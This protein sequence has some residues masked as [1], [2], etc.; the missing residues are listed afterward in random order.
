MKK[1]ILLIA[2]GFLLSLAIPQELQHVTGVVNV[3]V[4]VRVFD[5][6]KFV[7]DL[8]I[9]D[10]AVFEDGQP[11][12]IAALYMIR[13]TK[14]QKEEAAG[15]AATTP[16]P[17]TGRHIVLL[18]EVNDPLPK[19]NEALDFFFSEVLQPE[20]TLTVTTPRKTYHLK[21]ET[22]AHVPR[23]EVARQLKEKLRPD[24]V[25]GASEYRSILRDIRDLVNDFNVDEDLKEQMLLEYI[26][27]LR[28]RIGL[29]ESRLRAFAQTLKVQ[30]GQKYVFLFYQRERVVLPPLSDFASTELRR[31]LDFNTKDIERIFADA[32]LTVHLIYLTQTTTSALEI[33]DQMRGSTLDTKDLSEN[34]Y[35]AFKEMAQ[36]TGGITEATGNALASFQKAVTASENYYILYYAP[37]GYRADG[38]FKE[39]RVTVKGKS[40]R[41]TNRAGYFAN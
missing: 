40:Y 9:N 23:T 1:L 5:G 30:E 39:I 17:K 8:T 20:D 35:G 31:S 11:Q 38:K 18:F 2:V 14:V 34:I 3:E 12:K 36:A 24:I 4:P 6:D 37:V 33:T 26:R 25:A 15:P 19:L 22:F 32:S 13:K 41:V 7:D 16:V 10:F 29:D 21:P 28:D 27:R